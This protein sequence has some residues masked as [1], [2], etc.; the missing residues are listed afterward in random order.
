MESL[1]MSRIPP[2]NVVTHGPGDLV[3]PPAARRQDPPEIVAFREELAKLKPENV[4]VKVDD[5]NKLPYSDPRVRNFGRMVCLEETLKLFDGRGTPI[6]SPKRIPLQLNSRSSTP[7][8]EDLYTLEINGSPILY[9]PHPLRLQLIYARLKSDHF[10]LFSGGPHSF[11]STYEPPCT[12]M[13]A[14]FALSSIAPGQCCLPN[15]ALLI[16]PGLEFA[17]AIFRG[18]NDGLEIFPTKKS[19]RQFHVQTSPHKLRQGYPSHLRTDGQDYLK[20][21]KPDEVKWGKVF[22]SGEQSICY[23]FGKIWIVE[24]SQSDHGTYVLTTEH[25]DSLIKMSRDRIRYAEPRLAGFIEHLV[26]PPKDQP[27]RESTWQQRIDAL[28]KEG[29][30]N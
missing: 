27:L 4:G 7:Q 1:C 20:N 21:C 17:L 14:Y 8:I 25:F 18:V 29:R 28:F 3:L 6:I 12:D 10:H 16:G 9:S 26:H 22:A 5:I 11:S 13:R 19:T 30:E 23:R 24:C 15:G 2:T